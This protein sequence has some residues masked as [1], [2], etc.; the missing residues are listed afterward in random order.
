MV[1]SKGFGVGRRLL[2]GDDIVVL[3]LP[4]LQ[5]SS[6]PEFQIA[7]LEQAQEERERK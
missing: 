3:D 2:R 5:I 7:N 4:P 1:E 6:L